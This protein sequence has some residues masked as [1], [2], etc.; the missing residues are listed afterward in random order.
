MTLINFVREQHPGYDEYSD[1]DVLE[2]YRLKYHPEN[3]LE[4]LEEAFRLKQEAEQKEKTDQ[5]GIVG[6][7]GRG[8]YRGKEQT[9]GLLTDVLPGIAGHIVGAEGYLFLFVQL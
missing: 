4:D 8:L 6:S 2:A 7:F 3:S 9:M 5:L 1:A